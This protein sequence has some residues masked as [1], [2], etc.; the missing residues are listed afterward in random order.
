MTIS[1][2]TNL[3][4][5]VNEELLKFLKFTYFGNLQDPIEASVNRAYRDMCRTLDFEDI[6]ENDKKNFKKEVK[7]ILKNIIKNKDKNQNIKNIKNQ[8]EF[9]IW[10]HRICDNII[11][12][13]EKIEKI[14]KNNEGKEEKIQFTYGQAQ[15][16]VNM[17]IKYLYMLNEHTF[18]NVFDF[19]HVPV[20]NYSFKSVKDKLKIKKPTKKSWSRWD[21]YDEYLEYQND[22]RKKLKEEDISPLRWEFENWLNEAEKEAQKVKK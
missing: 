3:K 6:D 5:N 8:D 11:E 15:K 14:K 2:E 13:S 1:N 10:H 16:W 12:K 22:I 9:D 21:N 4:T 18:D 20:D 17:T 7:A 19:L